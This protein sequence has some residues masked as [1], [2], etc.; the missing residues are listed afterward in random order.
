MVEGPQQSCKVLRFQER[1]VAL[2]VD[3][4]IG[5]DDLGDSMDSVG[6]AGQIGRGELKGPAAALAKFSYFGGVRSD[7]NVAELGTG[8]RCFVD[9]CQHGFTSN[10]TKNFAREARRSQTC[11]DN[12]EDDRLPLFA[13]A[14]IKYDWNW[15]CRDG[16]P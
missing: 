9:P 12:A 11:R 4:D 14:R 6:A 13:L 2:D 15:L 5:L 3:V 10:G 8:L 7:E 1:L 16:S